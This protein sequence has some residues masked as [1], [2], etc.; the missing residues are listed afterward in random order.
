MG[1]CSSPSF[2]SGLS[3]ENLPSS[4]GFYRLACQTRDGLPRPQTPANPGLLILLLGPVARSRRPDE[5]GFRFGEAAERVTPKGRVRVRPPKLPFPPPP[6]DPRRAT[7]FSSQWSG[8]PFRG[9]WIYPLHSLA[10][11]PSFDWMD[12]LISSAGFGFLFVGRLV[13]GRRAAVD[14]LHSLVIRLGSPSSAR[15]ILTLVGTSELPAT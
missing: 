8:H 15:T 7:L 10:C 1:T 2:A 14:P 13:W 12:S 9:T 6:P 5:L 11:N 4:V 3:Q